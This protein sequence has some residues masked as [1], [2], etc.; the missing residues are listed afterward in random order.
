MIESLKR[1]ISIASCWASTRTAVLD[2]VERFEDSY[3]ITQEFREWIVCLGE[4][5]EQL[6]DSVLMVPKFSRDG[7]I[8][9]INDTDELLEI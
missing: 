5:P 2:G 9:E 4:H 6:S 3:A 7:L 8:E 1:R